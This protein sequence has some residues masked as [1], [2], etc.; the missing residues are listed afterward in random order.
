MFNA[1]QIDALA[2]LVNEV[3]AELHREWE[4]HIERVEQ[5]LL[6]T[7]VRLIRPGEAAEVQCRALS[8]RLAIMEG[9]IERQ[10]SGIAERLPNWR[11]RDVA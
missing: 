9:K 7:V 4:Q 10:L 6:D 2:H 11:K 8:D 5:R 3:R 1:D